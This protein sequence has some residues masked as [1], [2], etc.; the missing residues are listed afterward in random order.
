MR[1][2]V[3]GDAYV[4][5]ALAGF[6]PARETM[7]KAK[8]AAETALELSPELAEAYAARAAVA[9]YYEW[10]WSEAEDLVRQAIRLSPGYEIAHH[11]YAMGCLLPQGRFK[12]A[13]AEMRNAAEGHP[14][15][16]F[17]TACIGIVHYYTHEYRKALMDFDRALEL[18]PQYHLALWHRGWALQC[19][20]DHD[21]A[22]TT[23]QAAADVSRRAPQ[24]VA[25]L[26]QCYAAADKIDEARA[27]LRELTSVAKTRF[28]SSYDLALVYTSLGD[29]RRALEALAV[30]FEERAP[31]L[32][33]IHV[34]P[35]LDRLRS[36]KSFQDLAYRVVRPVLTEN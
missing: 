23:V 26:A 22:I 28:V 33:R 32:S 14:D 2:R 8:S 29:N 24:V 12:S 35:I 7:P 6:L 18:Q 27:L 17:I 10:N 5:L 3:L 4:M 19:L 20:G 34:Q 30:A 13:M 9:A 15:S 1:A 36:E 11:L 25:A 16:A 21:D 31:M